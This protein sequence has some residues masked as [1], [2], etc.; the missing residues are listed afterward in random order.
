M[1]GRE[2]AVEIAQ[3]DNRPDAIQAYSDYFAAG[4]IAGF[5][6]TGIRIPEEIAI[7]GFDNRELACLVWPSLTTV[8]QP[9]YRTG[10]LAAEKLLD[11]INCKTEFGGAKVKVPMSLI[12][13]NST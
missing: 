3:M 7:C 10:E 2:L 9:N 12:I 6:E 11:K 13:R 8:E 4:L 5:H 1:I